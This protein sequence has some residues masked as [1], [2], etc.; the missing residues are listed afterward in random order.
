VC[1]PYVINSYC[2]NFRIANIAF[3][4][5]VLNHIFDYLFIIL[6]IGI[7]TFIYTISKENFRDIPPNDEIVYIMSCILYN[8]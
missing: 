7:G 5:C 1:M 4:I 6:N 2:S 3:I 8:F